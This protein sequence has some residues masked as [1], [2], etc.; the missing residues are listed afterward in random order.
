MEALRMR[1][2]RVMGETSARLKALGILP[3]L[4]P[5]A[6]MFLWCRLPDGIDAADIARKA[7]AQKV[8]LAP[9][10]AFSP[11]QASG[12]YLRFNVAQSTDARI[13]KSLERAMQGR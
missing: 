2:S 9:G 13:F 10:N 1:L 6:G 11:S 5:Q 8:V 4:E 7:L 3:W 12:G